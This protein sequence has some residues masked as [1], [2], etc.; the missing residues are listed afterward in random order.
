M[1]RSRPLLHLFE[2]RAA[3]EEK[4]RLEILV[5]EL[6]PGPIR[7]EIQQ[8]IRQLETA[9]TV[10]KWVSAPGLKSPAP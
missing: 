8:K 4:K 10:D 1:P 7:D 2:N 9:A 6:S 5:S 3:N